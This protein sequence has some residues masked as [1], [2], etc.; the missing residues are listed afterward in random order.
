MIEKKKRQGYR[1]MEQQMEATK[2]Y[3]AN[4]PEARERKKISNLRSNGKNFIKNYAELED[5][6]EFEILIQERKNFLKSS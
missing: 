6:E 4:N 5:L 1:T 2:R 3:L